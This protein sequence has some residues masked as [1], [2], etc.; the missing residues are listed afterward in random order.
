MQKYLDKNSVQPIFDSF[1]SHSRIGSV[2][3]QNQATQE[4]SLNV[5]FKVKAMSDYKRDNQKLI[6]KQIIERGQNI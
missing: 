2:L 1:Q 6:D 3:K 5:D 4:R